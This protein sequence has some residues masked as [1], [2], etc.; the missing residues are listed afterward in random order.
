MGGYGWGALFTIHLF[1]TSLTKPPTPQL[2]SHQYNKL[3]I[4][5]GWDDAPLAAEGR[6]QAA[7]AGKLLRLHGIEFDVVYTSWL[8]RAIETA[9]AIVDELDLLW[10]P[11][12]KSWRLNER[13]YGELTGMSKRGIAEKYGESQLKVHPLTSPPHLFL[14][15]IFSLSPLSPSLS[16][17]PGAGATKCA[18]LPCTPSQWRTLATTIVTSST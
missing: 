14:T 15:A 17:R 6:K 5:T 16:T 4:F 11:I 2:S 12:F 9:W 8:S 13:M 10:L 3:G 18:P 7:D 1:A